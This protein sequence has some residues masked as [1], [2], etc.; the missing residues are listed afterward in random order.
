MKIKNKLL[1]AMLIIPI[2]LIAVGL[3]T[4]ARA[5]IDIRLEL[6][7]PYSEVTLAASYF[8]LSTF[9]IAM[10]ILIIV[11]LL[12]GFYNK[13]RLQEYL[14]DKPGKYLSFP[15]MIVP[16]LGVFGIILGIVGV[17]IAL[18]YRLPIDSYAKGPTH[19]YYLLAGSIFVI[20]YLAFIFSYLVNK[21]R[22][23]QALAILINDSNKVLRRDFNRRIPIILM[24]LAVLGIA[25]SSFGFYDLYELNGSV[26]AEADSFI[27]LLG[28]GLY[29]IISI[30]YFYYEL[31]NNK[32]I[33]RLVMDK[34]N[35]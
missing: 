23:E 24:A 33:N 10:A 26:V 27:F 34:V 31:H 15:F 4:S 9:I 6:P 13:R 3:L 16:M 14:N 8:F 30:P 25:A 32:I 35:N 5:L 17:I 22:E 11:F 7:A 28:L 1:D 2:V 29:F 21:D 20:I 12:R 18:L 19:Y